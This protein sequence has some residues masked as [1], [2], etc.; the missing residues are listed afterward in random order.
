M[1]LAVQAVDSTLHSDVREA[2][3]ESP[4]MDHPGISM[5]HINRFQDRSRFHFNI[6]YF[7]LLVFFALFILSRPGHR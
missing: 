1:I 6:S 4:K 7:V 3:V 5:V 2:E